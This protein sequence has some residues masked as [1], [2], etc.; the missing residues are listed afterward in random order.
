M[1]LWAV[2]CAPA[3]GPRQ[4]G[5]A[6]PPTSAARS[7]LRLKLDVTR[8]NVSAGVGT[9][10]G[11]LNA[12]SAVERSA[13]GKLRRSWEKEAGLT[14]TR[15]EEVH[16]PFFARLW[17]RMSP[18]AEKRGQGEHRR[19]LLAGLAG[20]VV[21]VGVG[22]GLNFAHYPPEVSELVAIEP[23]P[24]LRE[25][26]VEAAAEAPVPVHVLPGLAEELPAEMPPSTPGSPRSF[27]AQCPTRRGPSASSIGRSSPAASCAS[28]NTWSQTVR[29]WRRPSES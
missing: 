15:S 1:L 13:D 29:P 17:T 8:R 25:R 24:Y 27:R 4:R 9:S 28:T 10:R 6:I 20:R 7:L 2:G 23:E 16:H 21:E 11:P 19:K 14:R 22:N 18:K 26:A 3:P 12:A 5:L